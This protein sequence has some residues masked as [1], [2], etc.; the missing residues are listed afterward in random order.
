MPRCCILD[1]R[2]ESPDD[3]A[4][5]VLWEYAPLH[6]SLKEITLLDQ[7][8]MSLSWSRAR[9]VQGVREEASLAHHIKAKR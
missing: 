9:G 7:I 4:N 2:Q 1:G 5:G 6:D 3:P 8:T